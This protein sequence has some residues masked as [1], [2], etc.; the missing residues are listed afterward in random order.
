MKKKSTKGFWEMQ[1]RKN[2]FIG[3]TETVRPIFKTLKLKQVAAAGY[4]Q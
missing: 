2:V 1:G 3:Q 4:Q